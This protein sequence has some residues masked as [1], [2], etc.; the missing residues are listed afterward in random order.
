MTSTNIFTSQKK[1]KKGRS[2]IPFYDVYSWNG[3]GN[4]VRE[5]PSVRK[6]MDQMWQIR[7]LQKKDVKNR[8][9]PEIFNIFMT[10]KF[11]FKRYY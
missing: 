6:E 1:S 4:S 9:S 5:D 11:L 8:A 2:V 10:S 7:E 3:I